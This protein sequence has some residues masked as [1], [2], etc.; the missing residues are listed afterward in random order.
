MII[1][2]VVLVGLFLSLLHNMGKRNASVIDDLCD[3]EKKAVVL[4]PDCD[5]IALSNIIYTLQKRAWG[6]VKADTAARLGVLQSRL[7]ASYD[8]LGQTDSVFP[9]VKDPESAGIGKM[10]VKVFE[11]KV[12]DKWWKRKLNIKDE[13]PCKVDTV[14]LTTYFRDSLNQPCPAIVGFVATDSTGMN[15]GTN[16]SS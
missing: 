7:Q 10:T 8:K 6:Q 16:P 9:Y 14:L 2:S 4:S 15:K 3:K 13:V 12:S 5:S 1:V 11:K